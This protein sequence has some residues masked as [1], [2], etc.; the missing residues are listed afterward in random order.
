M[1]K[2]LLSV[3]SVLALSAGVQAQTVH[4]YDIATLYETIKTEASAAGP[5]TL[6][7]DN[8][9]LLNDDRVDGIFTLKS[10]SNRTFRIDA[11][12]VTFENGE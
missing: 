12:D 4:K 7:S 9:Y 6:V 1:K 10:P 5:A 11:A 8:K 2:L 3:F